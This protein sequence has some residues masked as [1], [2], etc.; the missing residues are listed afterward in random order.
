MTLCIA[1]SMNPSNEIITT[2]YQP[3]VSFSLFLGTTTQYSVK[4]I[5]LLQAI[6]GIPRAIQ[7]RIAVDK[8]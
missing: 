8:I 2:S 6:N 4:E 1:F 5:A 3:N 7:L